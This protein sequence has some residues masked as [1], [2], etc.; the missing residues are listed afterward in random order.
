[1]LCLWTRKY[2][3]MSVFSQAFCSFSTPF[4]V[5]RVFFIHQVRLAIPQRDH[6]SALTFKVNYVTW[7]RIVYCGKFVQRIVQKFQILL[8]EISRSLFARNGSGTDHPWPP[9]WETCSYNCMTS[10][11]LWLFKERHIFSWFAM[12]CACTRLFTSLFMCAG[13]GTFTVWKKRVWELFIQI[14]KTFLNSFYTR[15]RLGLVRKENENWTESL[16]VILLFSRDPNSL[17]VNTYLDVKPLWFP[18]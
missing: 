16:I 11:C 10:H 14:M 17:F 15:W 4:Q 5:S 3:L 1:M 8:I 13:F 12:Y 9:K 18:W 2:M 6:S 7:I